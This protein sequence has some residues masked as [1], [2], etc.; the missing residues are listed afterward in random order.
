MI[1][2]FHYAAAQGFNHLMTTGLHYAENTEPLKNAG[3]VWAVVRSGDVFDC[4]SSG[5]R[6]RGVFTRRLAKIAK[7]FSI[8]TCCNKAIY[9]MGYEL[10]NRPDWVEIPCRRLCIW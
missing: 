10:N 3:T 4:V 8:S 7:C 5:R 2:S 1:R 9:E 6:Q